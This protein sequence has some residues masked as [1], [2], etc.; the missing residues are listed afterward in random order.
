MTDPT[1]R[2]SNGVANDGTPN[3]QVWSSVT[4]LWR[5]PTLRLVT[6]AT[7][8]VGVQAASLIPYQSLIAVQKFG[9]SDAQYSMVLLAAAAIGV[10]SSLL[11]GAYTDQTARRRDPAIAAACL[12]TLGL[13]TVWVLP[14]SLSFVVAHALLLPLAWTVF[15]Q[16]FALARLAASGYAQT[17]R[18]GAMTAI[19]ALFALPFVVVL[20]LWAVAF[21]WGISLLSVYIVAGTAAAAAAVLIIRYWPR[22]GS[23]SW[24][25]EQ[26]GLTLIQSL[27]EMGRIR[28]V[29]RTLL[30]GTVQGGITLY[31]ALTG[32]ILTNAGRST[33]EVGIFI[34]LIAGLE[35]PFMILAGGLLHRVTKTEMISAAA[36]LYAG[37]LVV[38]PLTGGSPW[39]WALIVPAAMGAGVILSVSIA[40]VQDLM[41][42]RPGAGGALIAVL[43]VSGQIAAAAI[44]AVG[45][46]IGGY[47]TASLLGSGTIAMAGTCLWWLDRQP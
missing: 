32:L 10:T 28:V 38:F 2:R 6:A 25:D 34:G 43:N 19:R 39:L 9:L 13:L 12:M 11:V 3:R 40:Y 15:G 36:L 42:D 30:A 41:S 18:D 33:G 1:I 26:S 20:P 14:T 44:F 31:M 23:G 37:F 47:G 4:L 27:A 21:Q 5:D 29:V 8:L 46:W 45:T 7:L 22:D 17:Q 24:S 16:M 35:V